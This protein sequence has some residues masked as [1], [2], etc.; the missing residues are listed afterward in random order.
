[1][2]TNLVRLFENK[3]RRLNWE[4]RKCISLGIFLSFRKDEQSMKW[5]KW[6]LLLM[7]TNESTK[8]K[9]FYNGKK[10]CGCTKCI[11]VFVTFYDLYVSTLYLF[12]KSHLSCRVINP[13]SIWV[14]LF[15]RQNCLKA[16]KTKHSYL[17]LLFD[18]HKLRRGCQCFWERST[19]YV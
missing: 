3:K 18:W 4:I 17:Y 13:R 5:E 15:G 14:Y 12:S 9:N 8:R 19:F 11:D 6:V 7:K 16:N 1:M 10:W 2:K